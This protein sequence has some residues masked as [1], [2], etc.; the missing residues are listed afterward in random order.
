MAA[1]IDGVPVAIPPPDG[2]KVNF[3]NPQRNSVTEAYWLYGIGNFLS[4]AFI[5]QRVYVK[6]FLQRKFRIGDG[7]SD[8][9]IFW[10]FC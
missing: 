3:E 9:P 6:G 2:Y 10:S 4:L 8:A 7:Q 1:V 5:L